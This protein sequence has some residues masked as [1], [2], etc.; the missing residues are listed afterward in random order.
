M[1]HTSWAPYQSTPAV[2]RWRYVF[3][4][5]LIYF[6]N[7]STL[8]WAISL[9]S[10]C[11]SQEDGDFI[12]FKNVITSLDE[13]GKIITRR[14]HVTIGFSCRYPKAIN[15]YSHYLN[16]KSDYVFTE[17]SFGSFSYTFEVFTDG[18]FTTAIAPS[19]FPV[20][21]DLLD[22]IYMGIKSQSSLTNTRM[23]VESCRGT[24]TVNPKGPIYYDLIS[25]G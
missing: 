15:V 4:S 20:E 12:I 5:L 16:K 24:P 13:P 6:L 1:T 21:Y 17:A 14:G 19:S 2:H 3:V 11:A 7:H 9:V 10:F 8:N 18:N 22:M 23:F 25:N